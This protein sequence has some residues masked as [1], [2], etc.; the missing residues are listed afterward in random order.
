MAQHPPK[1]GEAM[2]KQQDTQSQQAASVLHRKTSVGKA[3][4]QARAMSLPKAFRLSFAK[5]A[6]ELLE[7]AL[8]VIGVR[9]QLCTHAQLAD[10]LDEKALLVLLDGSFQRRGMAMFDAA[11]VGGLIQQQTMGKVMPAPPEETRPLTATDAA[12]CAPFLDDLLSRAA[13]LP[14]E[15]AQRLLI[16]GFRFGTHSEEPRQLMMALDRPDYDVFHLTVD[17]AGGVRQGQVMLCF[18]LVDENLTQDSDGSDDTGGAR[19][20]KSGSQMERTVLGLTVELNIALARIQ[21]PLSDLQGLQVGQVLDLGVSSFEQAVVQTQEGRRLS[22]GKLGQIDGVRALQLEHAMPPL[23][24]PRRRA[25]DRPDLDLPHVSGDGTGTQSMPEPDMK[26]LP[27]TLPM[28]LPGTAPEP[29]MPD[30]PDLAAP[31]GVAGLPDLPDLPSAAPDMGALPDLPDL[32]D[33]PDFSD[34]SDLPD[35]EDG[36]P[37]MS[38]T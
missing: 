37:E 7:M 1:V 14:E 10:L 29:A 26:Q 5:A 17:M 16:E 38:I 21:L 9:Q 15:D 4:H 30:L 35:F 8:A 36:P 12:I 28:D 19:A 6:D 13:K 24:E 27:A 2:E 11:F 25:S 3:E 33:L 20:Q 18:P 23:I 31:E 32:G 22:R 34:M